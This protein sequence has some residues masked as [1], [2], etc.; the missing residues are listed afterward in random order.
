M[1]KHPTSPAVWEAT[2]GGHLSLALSRVLNPELHYGG[3][4]QKESGRAAQRN[5]R[6]FSCQVEGKWEASGKF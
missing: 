2:K 1:S 3:G 6:D 4:G 5:L